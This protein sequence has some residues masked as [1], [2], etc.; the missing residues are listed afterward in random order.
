LRIFVTKVFGRFA[1]SESISDDR[2]REAIGR[3]NAGLVDADLGS[4]LIKQRIGR[5]RQGRSRGYRTVIAFRERDRALFLHGFAKNERDNIDQNDLARL[6][7]LAAVYLTASNE[8]LE[9][10]CAAGELKEVS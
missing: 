10:W 2:L 4:G 5:Q 9:A 6:R 8:E 3:A 1:R 7:K